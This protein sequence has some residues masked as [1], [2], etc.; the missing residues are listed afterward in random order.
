M[1]WSDIEAI[2]SHG[3]YSIDQ[4]LPPSEA[5]A[6]RVVRESVDTATMVGVEQ[7]RRPL[8]GTKD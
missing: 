5:Q 1:K 7:G 3:I 2:E 4:P 6:L 8:D